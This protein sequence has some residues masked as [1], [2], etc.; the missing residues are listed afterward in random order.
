MFWIFAI[1]DPTQPEH[2]NG[3]VTVRLLLQDPSE[4]EIRQRAYEIFILRGEEPGSEQAD[5]EQ[6]ERELRQRLFAES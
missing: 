1:D 5:W 2:R 3:L 4:H 6:A